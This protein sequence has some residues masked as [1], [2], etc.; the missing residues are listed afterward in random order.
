[1]GDMLIRGI[2]EALKS[3]IEAAARQHGQSLSDEAI[4]LLRKGIVSEKQAGSLP[5]NSAWDIIRADFE[6]HG[7]VDDQFAQVLE[8]VEEE[9]K[10]YFGRP[11]EI[12]E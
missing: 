11:S 6:I 3:E 10:R 2:P 5:E 8:E 1:M 12:A 9:R 4:N 7:A